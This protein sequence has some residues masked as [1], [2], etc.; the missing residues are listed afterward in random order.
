MT[1]HTRERERERERVPNE[2]QSNASQALA[3]REDVREVHTW[4][5]SCLS[6]KRERE[7]ESFIVYKMFRDYHMTAGRKVRG[8]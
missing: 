4:K 2:D 7:R 5:V 3:F 8:P 6:D 1:P